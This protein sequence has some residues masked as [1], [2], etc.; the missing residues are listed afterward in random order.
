MRT[1]DIVA[2][3]TTTLLAEAQNKIEA[4]AEA[5]HFRHRDVGAA[6]GKPENPKSPFLGFLG[7]VPSL[8]KDQQRRAHAG[9]IDRVLA[10][11]E[12]YRDKSK[13]IL[14]LIRDLEECSTSQRRHPGLAPSAPDPI[15]TALKKEDVEAVEPL[16]ECLAWDD[17]LTRAVF[18]GGAFQNGRIPGTVAE[19][20]YLT[21]CHILQIRRFGPLTEHGWEVHAGNRAAVV[22]EIRKYWEKHRALTP[23]ERWYQI[24][25][26]DH[27][28]PSQWVEAASRIVQPVDVESRGGWVFSPIRRPGEAPPIRGESLRSKSDPSVAEL[29]AKRVSQIAKSDPHT[30]D[31]IFRSGKATDVALVLARWDSKAAIPVMRSQLDVVKWVRTRWPD[32]SHD[33]ILVGG[34]AR[35]YTALQNAGDTG[36]NRDYAAWIRALPVPSSPSQ[37]RLF[38][39]LWQQPQ[40]PEIAAAADWLFNN[41][42]S[43]WHCLPKTKD[44]FG[45]IGDLVASPLMGVA[46]FQESLLANLGDR[47]SIGQ[48]W[49]QDG[50]LKMNPV[51]NL[52]QRSIAKEDPLLPKPGEK[53]TFRVCDWCAL[54]LSWLEGSPEFEAYWPQAKRD[55]AVRDAETFVRDWADRFA[56]N[57][58]Q[59]LLFDPPFHPA[60]MIFERRTVP[61]TEAQVRAHTAIFS[62]AGPDKVRAVALEPFPTEAKWITKRFLKRHQVYDDKTKAQEIVAEFD[63]TGWIWQAEERLEGGQWKRYY[64]FV[65][66]HIVAKVLAEEIEL[67]PPIRPAAARQP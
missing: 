64:G 7:P 44:T 24:L 53:Q 23:A 50:H 46:A 10:H 3:Q 48:I 55:T 47:S 25:A 63:Q 59:K 1:D 5:R 27:A 30:S 32:S 56:W 29:M 8:L 15:V 41:A 31:E 6:S 54:Q 18:F 34:P 61:A 60:R 43:P 26:D 45:E 17:R 21:L 9:T 62:L 28:Q 4:A 20:A 40:D 42:T 39:P 38:R 16:L 2:F 66:R 11:P 13:R 33:G 67:T 22:A 52:R 37:L 14:A 51:L 36:I 35:L 19:A 49:F 65:G 12:K 58:T 57:D